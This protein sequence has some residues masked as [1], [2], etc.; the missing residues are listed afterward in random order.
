MEKSES[1]DWYLDYKRGEILAFIAR[2]SAAIVLDLVTSGSYI[3]IHF[4]NKAFT[5]N[6]KKNIYIVCE[7]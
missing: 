7:N 3:Q 5:E 4:Y 2:A 1:W 6:K